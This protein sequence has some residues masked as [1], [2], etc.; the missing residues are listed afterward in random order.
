MTR[1]TRLFNYS[2]M[3]TKLKTKMNVTYGAPNVYSDK[4]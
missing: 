1:I 3:M 4:L 2:I